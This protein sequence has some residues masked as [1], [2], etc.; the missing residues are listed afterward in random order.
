MQGISHI[1]HHVTLYNLVIITIK[2]HYNPYCFKKVFPIRISVQHM[3]KCT[4]LTV[5]LQL[6]GCSLMFVFGLSKHHCLLHYAALCLSGYIVLYGITLHYLSALALL[7]GALII[8][9]SF[10]F[11]LKKMPDLLLHSDNTCIYQWRF[12]KALR[13]VLRLLFWGIHL[14][15]F[16]AT[17]LVYYLIE[18]HCALASYIPILYCVMVANSVYS[19]CFLVEYFTHWSS[20]ITQTGF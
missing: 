13:F 19:Y 5:L 18:R 14:V 7:S 12:R 17:Y 15:A 11:L 9:T 1:N 3:H 10:I 4:N 6:M 16:S 8:Q 2:Q 20:T